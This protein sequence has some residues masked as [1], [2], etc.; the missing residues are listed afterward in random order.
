[1]SD[2]DTA[3][4]KKENAASDKS[5]G[6]N[7]DESA[8]AEITAQPGASS[9][10]KSDA[11]SGAAEKA[12]AGATINTS[13]AAASK[14]AKHKSSAAPK[15]W[16]GMFVLVLIPALLGAGAAIYWTNSAGNTRLT[17]LETRLA[18]ID[19]ASG[20]E[21]NLRGDLNAL[22]AQMA[23]IA[24]RVASLESAPAA[25]AAS[26]APVAPSTIDP[27]VAQLSARLSAI[28]NAVPVD[29]TARLNSF[30][31]R[32]AQD[33]LVARLNELEQSNNGET[34]LRAGRVLALSDLSR[35]ARGSTQFTIE[36]E[37]AAATLPDNAVLDALRPHASEGTPTMAQL[38][39]RFAEVARRALAA[40]RTS[41]AENIFAQLWNSFASLISIR[42]V[43]NVEGNDSG[44]RIAR[45]EA[46]LGRDDLA[47]AADEMGAL[48]GAA[49]QSVAP[50]LEDARARLAID[51]AIAGI[52]ARIVQMLAD[53][54]APANAP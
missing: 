6:S 30:A 35:A 50:W 37:A 13:K 18:E 15:A 24:T 14:P 51:G 22:D 25:A 31:P 47:A 46:A 52:N 53:Q 33:A 23:Q 19:V 10:A 12:K 32:E 29:L 44:A 27:R 9:N 40:E 28:E 17:Q 49:S 48:E 5:A 20:T 34:L 11:K 1:M 2:T 45:A 39:A 7:A 43:G 42:R 8:D 21:E 54:T 3:E 36:L 41:D 16:P 38:N 26:T 4:Q